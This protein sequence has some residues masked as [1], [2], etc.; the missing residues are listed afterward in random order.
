MMKLMPFVIVPV[1]LAGCHRH[2]SDADEFREA[3]QCGMEAPAVETLARQHGANEFQASGRYPGDPT[4]YAKKGS[5]VVDLW[6][7]AGHL[8]SVRQAEYFGVTGVKTSVRLDICT[9]MVSGYPTLRITAP[10]EL[11][12][13]HVSLNGSPLSQ[14]SGGENPQATLNTGTMVGLGDHTLMIEKEGWQPIVRTFRYHPTDFWP[15]QDLVVNISP[16]EVQSV[17][18]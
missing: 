5:S 6:F 2:W 15:E 14:L 12:N 8:V 16:A 1:L 4:H 9:G 18:R 17:L 3:L 11:K 13:A 10:A 7:E